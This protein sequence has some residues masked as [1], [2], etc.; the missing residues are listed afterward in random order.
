MTLLFLLTIAGLSFDPIK[1]P[2]ITIPTKKETIE[3]YCL[4][5]G[6]TYNQDTLAGTMECQ[7][8]GEIKRIPRMETK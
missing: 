1:T 6:P 3:I 5:H 4:K 2:W 8:V 7:E